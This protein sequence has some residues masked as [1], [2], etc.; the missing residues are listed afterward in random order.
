MSRG[1]AEGE[2]RSSRV[3]HGRLVQ[4]G[5]QATAAHGPGVNRFDDAPRARLDFI[6]VEGTR[7][8]QALRLAADLNDADARSAQA[9][10]E[11]TTARVLRES[12]VAWRRKAERFEELW[13]ALPDDAG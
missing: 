12:A 10:G 6:E 1:L 4:L 11:V 2:G 13:A 7:I 9:A 8:T 5:R 3:P